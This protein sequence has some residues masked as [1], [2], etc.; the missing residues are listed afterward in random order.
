MT[1]IF[2][3]KFRVFFEVEGEN[4][5]KKMKTASSNENLENRKKFIQNFIKHPLDCEPF[6]SM[7][8]VVYVKKLFEV[9]SENLL[10]FRFSNEN[11]QVCN[12]QTNKNLLITEDE[13]ILIEIKN[14]VELSKIVEKRDN[15]MESKSKE[16]ISLYL[17]F[18]KINAHIANKKKWW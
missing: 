16:L 12:Y 15:Y 7:S 3:D 17:M 4:P 18:K 14:G 6:V 2:Y 13:L 8:R 1:S 5:V 9:K 10:L 11:I